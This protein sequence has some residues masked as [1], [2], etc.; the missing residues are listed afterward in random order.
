MNIKEII[1]SP[2]ATFEL[3]K[4]M[5][6]RVNKLQDIKNTMSKEELFSLY[7]SINKDY[8]KKRTLIRAY[9][10][11]DEDLFEAHRKLASESLYYDIL[12]DG[13]SFDTNKA[14]D[15]Q[16]LMAFIPYTPQ[17][18]LIEAFEDDAKFVH[19]EK[20]RRQG[21]SKYVGN[22]EK[23]LLVHGQNE[24]MYATHKD[25]ESLDMIKGD[26]G[27]NSTFDYVRWLLDMSMWVPKN[28]RQGAM[29]GST[30][31][32]QINLNGNQLIGAVLG[33]GTAVGAGA[34]RAFIDEFDVV[35]DMY[36]NQANAM[37]GSFAMSVNYLY[38]FSTYRS[39]EFPFY[40][41]AEQ[42]PKGWSFFT[43]NWRDNPTCNNDWYQEACE[44][45]NDEILIARELD[46]DP[47][48]VRSGLIWGKYITEKNYTNK[49]PQGTKV[50][51]ADFGGG[52][53][54]TAFV[55]GVYQQDGTLTLVDLFETTEMDEYQIKDTLVKK[56]FDGVDVAGDRS[57]LFQTGAVGHDWYNVLR[58]VGIKI[59]PI[60]NKD[61]FYVQASVRK[62]FQD[63]K[64]KI[65]ETNKVLK[66]RILG[67][68][69]K[70]DKTNKDEHSHTGDALCYLW[71]SLHSQNEY[72]GWI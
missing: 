1:Q 67:Y 26:V 18:A 35:C 23:H 28:W 12:L 38:L 4:E 71:R 64:I 63:G 53:S 8:M 39:M 65:N 49:V 60:D 68:N 15:R 2:Q 11:S 3:L 51:G 52:T 34:T 70:N 54:A 69:W 46:I 20:S 5:S 25:L 33:K 9:I 59:K 19:I 40:K 22:V 48:K 72:R 61:I 29:G 50:I 37:M 47:T 31:E 21:G 7:E 32:K 44:K 36:P 27:H 17:I 57:V 24:I 10:L 13:W 56:G 42:K 45:L 6:G 62:G 41:L 30:K 14:I 55:L 43:L 66:K 58:R 16:P